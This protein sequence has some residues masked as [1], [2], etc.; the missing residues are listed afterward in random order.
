LEISRKSK[1]SVMLSDS[2][3]HDDGA[4]RLGDLFWLSLK[5]PA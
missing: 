3:K 4:E 2:G 1:K 5:A